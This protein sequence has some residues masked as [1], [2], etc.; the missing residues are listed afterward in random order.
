MF[1]L[2]TSLSTGVLGV[3]NY[4]VIIFTSLGIKGGLPTMANAIYTMIETS[5]SM[6]G[7]LLMDRYRWR[8]M[9]RKSDLV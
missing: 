3:G 8:I 5:M 9:L 1:L 6:V 7:A 4:K 2:F